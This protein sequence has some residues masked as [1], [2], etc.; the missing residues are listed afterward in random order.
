[1][2]S[3]GNGGR[4]VLD[5]QGS[6]AAGAPGGARTASRDRVQ[7]NWIARVFGVDLT[8][9][10]APVEIG[11]LRRPKSRLQSPLEG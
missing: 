10:P 2:I 3:R 6:G 7:P 11:S 1:M 8:Q 9:A 5:P 4:Y